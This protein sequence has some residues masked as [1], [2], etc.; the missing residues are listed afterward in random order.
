MQTARKQKNIAIKASD[1]VA[2]YVKQIRLQ[3]L[4]EANFLE[5]FLKPAISK[6]ESR[7]NDCSKFIYTGKKCSV[8]RATVESIVALIVAG[9]IAIFLLSVYNN[10][11]LASEH[12]SNK[13]Y[14]HK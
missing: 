5:L 9:A 6:K 12:S 8:C 3:S 10:R 11:N 13:K 14:C 7:K 4:A 2:A 1:K